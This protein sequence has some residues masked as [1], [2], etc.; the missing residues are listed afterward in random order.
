MDFRSRVTSIEHYHLIDDRPDQPNVISCELTVSGP[1]DLDAAMQAA[2]QIAPRQPMACARLEKGHWGRR[3]WVADNQSI[4]Q[5]RWETMD[6]AASDSPRSVDLWHGPAIRL[7]MQSN[8]ETT[9]LSFRIPHAAVDGVGGLQCLVE[10]LIAYHQVI[11]GA[12]RP[13]LRQLD[14]GQL[15]RRNHLRLLSR[16][17]I[18]K[19]WIQ[20]IAMLGA[21]KFLL[22]EVTSLSNAQGDEQPL[23]ASRDFQYLSRDISPDALRRLQQDA[24]SAGATV[25][26]FLVRSVFLG[27]HGFLK[28]AGRHQ[29]GQW[30][31][32]MIPINIRD[33][34]DRRMPAANRASIVQLDRTDRDFAD[35]DGMIWGLNYEL[36]NIR[37][38]NLEK[39]FLL[40]VRC[41]SVV[42]GLIRRS[43]RK[44]I[45][46]ATSVLTNLGS[47]L[48]R[49]KLP[50][51]DGKLVAG[52]LII[53][54]IDLIVPLR[55]LTAVGFAAVRYAGQQKLTLHYDPIQM[56][57][58]QAKQLMDFVVD[59]LQ[60][61][62]S[63]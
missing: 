24:R 36:G 20:P 11:T 55:P 25:N 40:I 53:E 29:E 23:D 18:A 28:A 27:I 7:L 56:S 26:E 17:F 30:L 2:R 9:R 3:Y 21:S 13:R 14:V 6:E 15:A 48:D 8:G 12:E 44:K 10:W 50:R 31:R 57:G 43:T 59:E 33:Y 51:R 41:M 37:K 5:L 35:P 62:Y 34:A 16:E 32:L 39:T 60:R 54:D 47:P 61:G 49:V 1:F 46:R 42:P 45:C 58:E 4:E 22:R 38:W 52:N 63:S 19:L